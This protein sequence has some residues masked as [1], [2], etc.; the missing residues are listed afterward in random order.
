MREEDRVNTAEV[1]QFDSADIVL[2]EKS[3]WMGREREQRNGGWGKERKRWVIFCKVRKGKHTV[4][5]IV[6][7]KN[8]R[9]QVKILLVKALHIKDV[10]YTSIPYKQYIL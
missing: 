6:C 5:S 9:E 2:R 8:V 3:G 1:L 7:G 4:A 10:S